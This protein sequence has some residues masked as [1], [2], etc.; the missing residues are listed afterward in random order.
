ML[1]RFAGDPLLGPTLRGIPVDPE[2]QPLTSEQ[3]MIFADE[4]YL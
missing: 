2:N 3:R 4:V 1:E